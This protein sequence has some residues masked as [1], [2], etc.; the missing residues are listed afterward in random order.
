MGAT[1]ARNTYRAVSLHDLW[2]GW[3]TLCTGGIWPGS[4]CS[5]HVLN[6]EAVSFLSLALDVKD[7][8]WKLG[9]PSAMGEKRYTQKKQK[10]PF[11]P[12]TI[13]WPYY[14]LGLLLSRALEMNLKRRKSR[15]SISL[16]VCGRIRAENGER[17]EKGGQ[18]LKA[19]VSRRSPHLMMKGD[20]PSFA[21]FLYSVSCQLNSGVSEVS[22]NFL[23]AKIHLK[24]RHFLF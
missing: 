7:P 16:R 19:K 1:H 24:P 9:I 14:I 21:T 3:E 6:F 11:Y 22:S 20:P 12:T 18:Q 17:E 23:I 10:A 8:L 13:F 5:H 15:N 4:G 2:S